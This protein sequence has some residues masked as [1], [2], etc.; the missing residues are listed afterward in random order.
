MKIIRLQIPGEFL[1]YIGFAELFNELEWVKILKAFQ[2]GQKQFF[3]LQHIKF[4]PQAMK[5]LSDEIK[6]KFNPEKIQILEVRE[7]ELFCIMYQ[8]K[9]SGFFPVIESG[10]WAFLFPIHASREVC[11]VNIIS[12]ESYIPNLLKTLSR[13]TPSY[14]LIGIMDINEIQSVNQILDQYS[15]PY[16]YFTKRQREIATYAA[17]KGFFNSPKKISAKEIAKKFDISVS[18]VNSHLRKAENTAMKFFF[19]KFS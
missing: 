7:D 2:Y 10:P 15:L 13:L 16:P 4:K 3:S 12:L 17:K 5:N 8:S 11:L 1:K 14:E 18:A 19:G 6:S 9:S